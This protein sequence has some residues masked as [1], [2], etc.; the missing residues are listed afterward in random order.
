MW[1]CNWEWP[2]NAPPHSLLLFW[3][4]VTK[5]TIQCSW[6][7]QERQIWCD[8]TWTIR[9][10]KIRFWMDSQM[11]FFFPAL[12]CSA[13][14]SFHLIQNCFQIRLSAQS[15][16]PSSLLTL[17][18]WRSSCRSTSHLGLLRHLCQQMH[19]ESE[20]KKHVNLKIWLQSD[21]GRCAPW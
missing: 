18:L 11:F 15:F 9:A 13:L 16:P 3:Q 12:S 20:K 19:R 4:L 14:H 1:R 2:A 8:Y 21:E 6:L 5:A 10:K 17:Y 7:R